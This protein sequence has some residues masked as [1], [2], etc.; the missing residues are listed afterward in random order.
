MSEG[1]APGRDGATEPLT[2]EESAQMRARRALAGYRDAA[3]KGAVGLF[4]AA[5]ALGLA[6]V[7][8][9][10]SPDPRPLLAY[11]GLT[12]VGTA[13]IAALSLVG[14]LLTLYRNSADA[15]RTRV[16]MPLATL[17]GLGFLIG[18]LFLL[19]TVD[20]LRAGGAS[21]FLLAPAAPA[22]P[23]VIVGTVYWRKAPRWPRGLALLACAAFVFPSLLWAWAALSP[24]GYGA[25]MLGMAP[26]SGGGSVMGVFVFPLLMDYLAAAFLL[27]GIRFHPLVIEDDRVSR[28]PVDDGGGPRAGERP[29]DD[30]VPGGGFGKL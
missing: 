4:M 23:L 25:V 10:P 11:L 16:E 14:V 27:V 17:A 28:G 7:L 9:L 12:L 5:G 19:T 8:I 3:G 20:P 26:L 21:A 18:V 13:A 29:A 15:A 6:E 2:R 22:I 30:W 24:G 1:G